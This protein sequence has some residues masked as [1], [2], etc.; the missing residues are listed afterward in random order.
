MKM[1]EFPLWCSGIGDSVLSLQWHG[2][3]LQLGAVGWGSGVAAAV[4]QITAA[5][6][7]QSWPGNF[8]MP[9]MWPKY[10]SPQTPKTNYKDV[11]YDIKNKKFGGREQ[12]M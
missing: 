4:V 1:W 3:D 10:P 5:A 8:H 6:Q 11:K 12:K 9:W 7:I 2:F